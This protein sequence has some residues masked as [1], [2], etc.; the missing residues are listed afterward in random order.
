V[1][2]H[3][4]HIRVFLCDIL[5]DLGFIT[6]EC[7]EFSEFT[8]H[9]YTPP[10]DLIVLGLSGDGK[11]DAEMLK[12]LAA[13]EFGGKI[14]LLGSRTYLV[15]AVREFGEKLGLK[16]LPVLHTPF[17]SA[18]LCR[19]VATF[20]PV[21]VPPPPPVDIANAVSAGW[22]EL[23]YQ[24]KIDVHTNAVEGAE[25]LIRIRHP[26]WGIVTPAYFMPADDDPQFGAISEFVINQ[27]VQDWRDFVVRYR[28]I[29]IAINLPVAFFQKPGAIPDLWRRMPDH[30]A[31][32]GMVI[33][34]NGAEVIRS[35]PLAK[36]VARQLRF[37]NIGISIADLGEE[38]PSL[39]G[40]EDFPF[41]ELKVD[42]KFITGC[43]DAPLKRKVCHRIIDLANH[44]GIRTVAEGVETRDDFHAVREMGFDLVQG[45][46]FGRPMAAKRFAT[47]LS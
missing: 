10:L 46:M 2:D 22:L 8:K 11:K 38:W 4:Q 35:L 14:L 5:D 40:L 25:A 20:L 9:L 29:E 15:S 16:M 21:E 17:G 18:S 33:E 28:P 43:A 7:A 30:P 44:Y 6:C 26:T 47:A 23:W 45:C 31:F 42:R 1:V 32:D 37:L 27:A 41:V 36:S 3:R 39:T 34:I 13:D 12:T 19:S 24:P